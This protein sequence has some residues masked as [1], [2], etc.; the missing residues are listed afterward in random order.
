MLDE[1]LLKE[2]Q[3]YIDKHLNQD[4]FALCESPIIIESDICKSIQYDELEDFGSY[5]ICR[6][7]KSEIKYSCGGRDKWQRQESGITKSSRMA[8]SAW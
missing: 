8:L 2:L 3:E 7:H 1:K 4:N 5:P 6:T